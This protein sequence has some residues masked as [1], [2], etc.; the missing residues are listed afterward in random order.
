[1]GNGEELAS[2]PMRP[3]P[4]E[5]LRA[6]SVCTRHLAYGY[7]LDPRERAA[8]LTLL[9][10]G[11]PGT[12]AADLDAAQKILRSARYFGRRQRDRASKLSVRFA[13]EATA[14]AVR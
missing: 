12:D 8:C 14:A 1:M 4:I 6:L 9:E 7:G 2:E 11:I 13:A 3:D 5:A 10:A